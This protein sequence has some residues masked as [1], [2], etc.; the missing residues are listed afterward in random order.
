[1]L[2]QHTEPEDGPE[3][4]H[5]VNGILDTWNHVTKE[6]GDREA[7]LDVVGPAAERYQNDL[8]KLSAIV[9]QIEEKQSVQKAFGPEPE[10]ISR[11]S[12]ELKVCVLK[13]F[14]SFFLPFT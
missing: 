7:K 4:E 10:K 12:E 8:E 3:L 13:C 6:V 9:A 14:Y 1:M 11:E 5:E 2:V